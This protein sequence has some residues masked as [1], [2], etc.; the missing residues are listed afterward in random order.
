MKCSSHRRLCLCLVVLLQ[1][2]CVDKGGR[3]SVSDSPNRSVHVEL[4]GNMRA[5][6]VPFVENAVDLIVAGQGLTSGLHIELYRSDWLDDG[7]AE[8][9]HEMAWAGDNTIRFARRTIG[10]STRS[11]RLTVRNISSQTIRYL[12]VSAS[13]LVILLD[14]PPAR[15]VS[16]AVT[17]S[18]DSDVSYISASG[19]FANRTAV[20]KASRNY[21]D[22][23]GTTASLAYDIV[24][25]DAKTE[26]TRH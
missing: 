21:S 19:E 25:T 4:T 1:S 11:H 18:S 22:S 26:I 23:I 9:Y 14:L 12:L 13:D 16:L 20:P 7:F 15:S 3:H 2:G 6:H 5:G 10:S 24:V 8:R 17:P